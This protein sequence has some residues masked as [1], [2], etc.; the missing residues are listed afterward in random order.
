MLKSVWIILNNGLCVYNANF[1]Q[2]DKQP[3]ED[4]FSGFVSA[5]FSFSSSMGDDQ[6]QSVT[7]KGSK[8]HYL[9]NKQGTIFTASTD[10]KIKDREVKNV[11][12]S[13]ETLYLQRF[14]IEETLIDTEDPRFRDLDTLIS[15]MVNQKSSRER[16]KSGQTIEQALRRALNGAGSIDETVKLVDEAISQGLT[17]KDKKVI[18]DLLNELTSFASKLQLD[19]DVINRLDVLNDNLFNW[20]D[21]AKIAV[22]KGW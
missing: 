22:T 20:L 5:L 15:A 21:K 4:L 10:R 11:L 9:V 14:P 19:K 8:L 13:I 17:K 1:S 6:I 3:S 16:T 2:K 12:Q 7:M 18:K